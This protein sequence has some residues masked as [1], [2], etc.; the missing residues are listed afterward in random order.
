M[1]G[2]QNRIEPVYFLYLFGDHLQ[3]VEIRVPVAFPPPFHQVP[4]F[5]RATSM[6]LSI[7]SFMSSSFVIDP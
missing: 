6:P 4:F 3:T 7:S 5:A 1:I 2:V